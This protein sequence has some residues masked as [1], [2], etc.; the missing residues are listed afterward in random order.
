MPTD[1]LISQELVSL[2][3]GV[4]EQPAIQRSGS[5]GEAQ[6]NC[7]SDVSRGVDRRAP[8]EHVDLISELATSLPSEEYKV[9]TVDLGG[10]LQ[11]AVFLF[12]EDVKVFKLSNG[13]AVS[14]SNAGAS[15]TPGAY[16]Y[17]ATTLAARDSFE[18]VT[19]GD[20][21]FITNKTV[22]TAIDGTLP[23]GTRAN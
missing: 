21:T 5:Q 6:V 9:H 1:A 14:V 10:D 18:A 8:M 23:A 12:D 19:V 2:V 3:N 17:L 15:G 4:S 22:E 20:T 7:L 11:F 16:T 13:D